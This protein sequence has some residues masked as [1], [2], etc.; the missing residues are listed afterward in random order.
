MYDE[1]KNVLVDFYELKNE[2]GGALQISLMSYD[3]NMP[4][5]QMVRRFNK[6]DGTVG[7]GKLG[8]MSKGEVIFFTENVEK[9]LEKM[10]EFEKEKVT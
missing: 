4:K 5:L 9:I 2:K 1:D 6:K 8:R 10:N 7:Y 3:G